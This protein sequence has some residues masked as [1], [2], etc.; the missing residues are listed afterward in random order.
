MDAQ[1]KTVSFG[2]Y[3]KKAVDLYVEEMT[4]EHER[5]VADLKS[6]VMKLSETVKNL[7]TMREV[8]LN[9]SSSTIDN[10][11]K[12]NDDLQAEVDRLKKELET[13]RQ[14]EN[15]SASR[16]ESISRTLLE[17]RENADKLMQETGRE[18]E[19]KRA[20][21]EADCNALVLETERECQ[22]MANETTETCERMSA[23]TTAE[24]ERLNTETVNRCQEM[25][26]TTFANCEAEKRRTREETEAMRTETEKYCAALK[27]DTEESCRTL[28]EQ[29]TA[30]C[31]DMKAQARTEAYSIRMNVK[32]E[33]ESLS[34][35]MAQLMNSVEL[36]VE[37]CEETKKVADQAFPNLV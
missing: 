31:E 22:R 21:V 14:K 1:F 32:K 11:K 4:A 34:D 30:E 9:E 23:D 24:C 36:V 37:A 3:D 16:Y 27:Q 17:A 13:F 2:G 25:K 19:E 12:V 26:E 5:E 6:N 7:H 15:E 8:N 33:C 35:Y 29:T 18:C 28:S 10:L 20:K